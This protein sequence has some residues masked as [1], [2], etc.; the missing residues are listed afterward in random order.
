MV[1]DDV[2]LHGTAKEAAMNGGS[3]GGEDIPEKAKGKPAKK[4]KGKSA[5]KTG[6]A[7]VPLNSG[8]DEHRDSPHSSGT[9]PALPTMTSGI[10]AGLSDNPEVRAGD[11]SAGDEGGSTMTVDVDEA[12][13]QKSAEP[14][15]EPDREPEGTVAETSA[16]EDDI[17][18]NA[19]TRPSR[20]QRWMRS[21]AVLLSAG[22]V[23][24]ALAVGLALSLS[25]L[26]NQNALA[27]SRTTAL[28]AARTYSVEL[29]SYNYRNL[30][31]D[32]GTVAANSTPSFRRTFA[33]SSDALKSTLTRYKAT[34]AASVVSAGVVSATTSRAV[35]LVFLD[36]NIA[37]STQ[38]KPTTDRSQVEI[39]L[40]RSGGRWLVDQVTLL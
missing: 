27:S 4:S 23:V 32:F 31:R 18:S 10:V 22:V 17:G 14:E 6:K 13:D 3:V 8:S 35:V 37:N 9:E 34:A 12:M 38:T 28:A 39:T 40:V 5:K 15:P 21:K 2:S 25:A 1:I 36:Q 33:E 20:R 30:N 7:G 16:D 26:S 24:V 29:A 19:E 11:D